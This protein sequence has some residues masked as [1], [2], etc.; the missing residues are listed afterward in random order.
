VV[1]RAC[2][3]CAKR[4]RPDFGT[5]R[6]CWDC[7]RAARQDDNTKEKE[8]NVNTT[9]A[10][11]VEGEALPDVYVAGSPATLFRSD[12]PKLVRARAVEVA[13]ELA[14][15][16]R[17]QNLYVKIRGEEYVLVEGWTLAG[18]MLGVFPVLEW[19]RRI[20][21]GWEARTEARTLS[22]AVIGAAESMCVRSERKWAKA[23]EHALRSMAATRS[24]SR[25][26]RQPL[27]FVMELAGFKATPAEDMPVE[28]PAAPPPERPR[29]PIPEAIRPTDDQVTELNRLLTEL[30][31]A[32]PDVDWTA[33]ARQ[34]AGVSGDMLTRTT[35]EQLLFKLRE[36]LEEAT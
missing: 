14:G 12:D 19:S 5:Q 15:I 1:S 31:T 8:E 26:L 6:L 24:T 4:F 3:A 20:D 27:G 23:E 32:Q 22:G 18:T 34:L 7:F 10:E 17:A 21:D 13:N 33:R 11:I 35:T 16:I 9:T 28:E 25:A 2:K 36:E 30:A 29:G